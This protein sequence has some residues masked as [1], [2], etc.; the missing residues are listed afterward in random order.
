[1]RDAPKPPYRDDHF[2]AA[3]KRLHELAG[4]GDID[5]P[6][7]RG[8]YNPVTTVTKGDCS[9]CVELDLLLRGLQTRQDAAKRF[10]ARA[11]DVL[12]GYND[13]SPSR[14]PRALWESDLD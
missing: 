1:M 2:R 4:R 9:V 11:P 13:G 8:V 3:V 5:Q 12:G 7:H 14:R 6:G 10:V